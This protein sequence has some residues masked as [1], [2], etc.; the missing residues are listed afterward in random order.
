MTGT[1]IIIA[2][3]AS[4]TQWVVTVHGIPQ[5]VANVIK[6]VSDS[7]VIFLLLVNVV[8]FILGCLMDSS[9]ALLL[10][11]PVLFPIARAFHIDPVHFGIILTANLGIGFITPPVGLSLLVACGI[12]KVPLEQVIKPLL[13]FIG[14]MII[15]L[16]LI[17]YWPGVVLL[18]PERIMGYVAK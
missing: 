2:V 11:T 12:S 18:A 15:I 9:A 3:F 16:L 10:A 14:I 17:T 13:P 4:V 7:P 1:V 8:Y 5:A 6:L